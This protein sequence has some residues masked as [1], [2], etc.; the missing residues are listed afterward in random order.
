M[1]AT[2]GTKLAQP[3]G[4]E[5]TYTFNGLTMHDRQVTDKIRILQIDGLQG[6]DLRD[7][8][9]ARPSAHGEV[10]GNL[11]LG[12]KTITIR[13][14]IEAGNIE[15][16]RD[17]QQAVRTAFM[18]SFVEKPLIISRAGQTGRDVQLMCRLFGNLDGAEEQGDSFSQ[19][20]FSVTLRASQP[21]FTSVNLK[22]FTV[23]IGSYE[24]LG[25]NPLTATP[26]RM[27]TVSGTAPNWSAGNLT[28]QASS[29][30]A[31]Q[32]VI[33]YRPNGPR[34]TMKFTVGSSAT[35]PV[36][37]LF[38]YRNGTSEVRGTINVNGA[39][40]TLV[41]SRVVGGTETII[42]TS[43]VFTMAAST[44]Y[45]FRFTAYNSTPTIVGEVFSTDP[46]ING[47][48][49]TLRNL[50]VAIGD[51]VNFPNTG[52][53]DVGIAANNGA[54]GWSAN[55][56]RI[57][58]RNAALTLTLPNLGNFQAEPIIR[59]TGYYK[60]ITQLIAKTGL[61]DEN[62]F[63]NLTINGDI[64]AATYLEYN[65][66]TGTLV[67]QTGANKF[68]QLYSGSNKPLVPA[69][70]NDF[71][72]IIQDPYVGGIG[73]GEVIVQPRIDVFYRDTWI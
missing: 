11:L 19:R 41:L 18:T 73:A 40:S 24:A 35:G 20:N 6:I 9:D 7:S 54:G 42:S 70:T 60:L 72:F 46:H 23:N 65:A 36:V 71:T 16:L 39:S 30:G 29:A 32:S 51:T 17:L 67:D 3:A 64:A 57:E 31:V 68:S 50:S 14:R 63:R 49:T 8:R 58:S 44:T 62:Y 22:Q 47:T 21:W 38:A 37:R 43:A 56:L 52:V 4:L 28:F 33:D 66:K 1:P 61:P 34:M 59:F 12:G 27:T 48:P 25:T 55:D 53:G 45:W 15:K 2:P 13:G 26:A 69:G 5:A 10:P